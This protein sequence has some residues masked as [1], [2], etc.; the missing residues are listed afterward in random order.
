M[1]P[2]GFRQ[3]PV[4][5]CRSDGGTVQVATA[6]NTFKCAIE[7]RADDSFALRLKGMASDRQQRRRARARRVSATPSS[8][9]AESGLTHPKSKFPTSRQRLGCTPPAA[10]DVCRDRLEPQSPSFFLCP[11]VGPARVAPI[12]AT[13]LAPVLVVGPCTIAFARR[14]AGPPGASRRLLGQAVQA[15]RQALSRPS[16]RG[17]EWCGT[18]VGPSCAAARF[19][20]EPAFGPSAGIAD[21]IHGRYQGQ[22]GPEIGAAAVRSH[23]AAVEPAVHDGKKQRAEARQARAR[24]APSTARS[25][26][27]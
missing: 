26:T 7:L 11:A 12:R 19:Q 23:G 21:R 15:G 1:R 3:T 4:G 13:C 25:D 22:A 8:I 10:A 14:C 27:A 24:R 17:Q 6:T 9:C 18:L 2:A 5:T 16:G 20:A